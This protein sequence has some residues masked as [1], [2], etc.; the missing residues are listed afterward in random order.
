VVVVGGG[1]L[2][3]EELTVKFRWSTLD[4]SDM[5]KKCRVFAMFVIVD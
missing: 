1:G 4:L 3:L 5:T 2:F